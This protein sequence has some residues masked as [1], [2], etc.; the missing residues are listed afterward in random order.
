MRRLRAT[1][2][3]FGV[4]PGAS[5]TVDAIAAQ[6]GQAAATDFYSSTA[7]YQVVYPE[8]IK[9]YG[10]SFNTQMGTTGIA[11]QGEASYKQDAPYAVD[12]VELFFAALT[13]TQPGVQVYQRDS[14]DGVGL[15]RT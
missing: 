5:P 12:D 8:D 6:A 2:T 10:L 13:P 1:S 9:L 3:S 7:R 14:P 15:P 4:P 11:L